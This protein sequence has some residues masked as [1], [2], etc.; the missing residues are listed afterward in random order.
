MNLGPENEVTEYKR[1]TSELKE[2]VASIASILNKHGEGELYFGVKNNGDV[3]GRI[4]FKYSGVEDALLRLNLMRDGRLTNAATVLFCRPRTVMLKMAIFATDARI[5]ILDMKQEQENLFKM[6]SMAEEYVMRNLKW[7]FIIDGP[8]ER[9]EVPEVPRA[10]VREAVMNAFC[11]RDYTSRLA[12]Q[13]DIFGEKVEIFSPG[14]F[15]DGTSPEAL[16]DDEAHPFSQSPNQ[17]IANALYKCKAIESY[18]TGLKRIKSLCADAGVMFEYQTVDQGAIVRFFRPNWFEESINNVSS[19]L[20]DLYKESN[21]PRTFATVGEAAIYLA[22]TQGFVNVKMLMATT[23]KSR[24]TASRALKK[25]ESENQLEWH[26]TSHNDPSQ[27][28]T[29]L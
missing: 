4:T 2:G 18:G 26:G 19:N 20:Q 6:A 28:F 3:C 10:V 1:S 27:Y 22:K 15:P 7:R 11:H 5:N 29:A 21:N 8:I 9:E 13:V 23:G 17:L 14:W 25:L 24:S 16:L 12:V